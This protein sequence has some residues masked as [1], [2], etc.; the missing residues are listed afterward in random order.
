MKSAGLLAA[1]ILFAI[2]VVWWL[3]HRYRSDINAW[4]TDNGHVIQ[5]IEQRAWSRG[6]YHWNSKHARIYMV[7]VENGAVYWF[8]FGNGFSG[9]EVEQETTDF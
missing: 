4:A 9:M 5:S 6:P 1:V 3:E 8:R 2:L 7:T